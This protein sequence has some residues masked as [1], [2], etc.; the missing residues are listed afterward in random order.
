MACQFNH[1]LARLSP[2]SMI[3]L[4]SQSMVRPVP[5]SMLMPFILSKAISAH[6]ADPKPQLITRVKIFIIILPRVPSK[7]HLLDHSTI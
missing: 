7:V 5:H 3:R 2:H 1:S 6:H 4:S